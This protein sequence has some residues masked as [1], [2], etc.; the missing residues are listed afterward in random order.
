MKKK[1][2]NEK[3]LSLKKLQMAKINTTNLRIIKG[4]DGNSNG[5]D[6]HPTK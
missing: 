4:G 1:P 5:H 6:T 3:K 2:Q